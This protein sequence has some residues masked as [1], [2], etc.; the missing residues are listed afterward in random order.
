MEAAPEPPRVEVIV[1]LGE[2]MVVIPLA[3]AAPPPVR[4]E[5]MTLLPDV[6]VVTVAPPAP[7]P[8]GP[9]EPEPVALAAGVTV[10]T[11]VEPP[12]RVVVMTTGPTD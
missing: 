1:V 6:I 4:V 10:V 11:S 12:E 9:P 8:P 5:V 2:V 3:P 7:T